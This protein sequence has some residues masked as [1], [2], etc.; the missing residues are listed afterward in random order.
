MGGY[1]LF[2]YLRLSLKCYWWSDSCV[3]RI[4]N[5]KR[6]MSS[7]HS[8]K[9]KAPFVCS[10]ICNCLCSSYRL[11][12]R[13][14]VSSIVLHMC[15]CASICLLLKI[16]MGTVPLLELRL[17]FWTKWTEL[18]RSPRTWLETHLLK[19]VQLMT[20]REFQPAFPCDVAV[21][22]SSHIGLFCF[23]F[24]LEINISWPSIFIGDIQDLHPQ[25]LISHKW[26]LKVLESPVN[27]PVGDILV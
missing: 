20:P 15:V 17:Y 24:L 6:I 22:A 9:K 4:I 13:S 1:F 21:I 10:I 23:V 27:V 25:S 19:P 11:W 3:M 16:M 26:S 7:E 18:R 5:T 14:T 2:C 8:W 12:I